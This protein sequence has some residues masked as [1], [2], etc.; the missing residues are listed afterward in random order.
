MNKAVVLIAETVALWNDKQ[1]LEAAV[2]GRNHAL[3]V[4]KAVP[5]WLLHADAELSKRLYLEM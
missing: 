4:F 2:N 1:S 3:K 5:S